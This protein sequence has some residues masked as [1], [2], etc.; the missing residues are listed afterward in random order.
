MK[1]NNYQ[2]TPET[3]AEVVTQLRT[4][5]RHSPDFRRV[6]TAMRRVY[7][8]YID[9]KTETV[10]IL[11]CGAFAKTDYLLKEY[12]AEPQMARKVNAARTRMRKCGFL[13][14]N[15]LREHAEDDVETLCSFVTLCSDEG[16]RRGRRHAQTVQSAVGKG[17]YDVLRMIVTHWDDDCVYGDID[18]DEWTGEATACYA[19]GNTHFEGDWTYLRK[20]FYAGAQLNLVRPEMRE[21]VLFPELIIFAPDYLVDISSVARC[22]TNY[23][24]SPVVTLIAKLQP[25]Q[26][27]EAIVLG[28]FAGQLLDEAVRNTDDNENSDGRRDY[29]DSVMEFFRNNAVSLLTAG[30]GPTFHDEARRQQK[31][32]EKAVK[33]DLKQAVACFEPKEGMV[34]PSFFSE[35]LGLQGRMDY[36]QLDFRVLMEQKSGKGGF[37][38]NGFVSPLHKEEHYVQLLLYMLLIRYNYRAVYEA[39]NRELH[40]FLLY[41]KYENPLLGLGFAPEL[42]FRAIKVRNRI[43]ASEL[44]Y[45]RE[46]AFRNVLDGLTPDRLNEKGD[47]GPLWQRYQRGQMMELLAPIHCATE[48]ERAYYYRFLTFIANEHVRS[49]LGNGTKECSGFAAT[50]QEPLEEKRMAGN[51]YDGLSLASPDADTQGAVETVKLH[52]NEDVDNDMAN[53]RTGDVVILYPYRKGTEPDARRMMVFRSRIE[54]IGADCITLS[55]RAPQSDARVFLWYKDMMWAIEHDFIEASYG[56]LYRGMHAFLSAPKDRRDLLMM[57]REPRIDTSLTLKGDYGGFNE[58]SLRVKQARDL[59]LIIGPPGTGKTSFGMLNTV[60]EELLEEGSSVLLLSYTN[61][62]VDEICSKLVED[63]IDFIRVGSALSSAPEYHD[64]LLSER[65]KAYKSVKGLKDML[66]NARVYVGT[67]TA[68]SSNVALLQI[69][70]FTLAVIDEASQILEPHLI[71]LLSARDGELSAIKKMV[72]IGD[73]KQLPAVVQQ[74]QDVSVVKE[75]MLHDI[76]LMDCRLSLFERLLRKYR[77][78]PAVTYMLSRQ[79]RM[80]HDIAMFPN[81]A[82]YN[83]KLSEVPLKHQLAGLPDAGNESDGM[84]TVLRSS[85]IAF[86]AAQEPHD[87][88]SDKVN[89]VE[90]DMIASAVRKIYEIEQEGFK[91]EETVGIIVPYRNQ[92]AA[93]R[94]IIDTYGIECLHDIAIDTVERFQGSQ[95]KYIIYGFTISKPYQLKFLTDNVFID[96]DGTVVDRKLNVAMTRA[97]EHLVMYGNPKLLQRNDTFARLMDFVKENGTFIGL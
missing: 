80:H 28:N 18:G 86:V 21:G 17:R 54:S 73:H 2:Y 74:P 48:L 92:I 35:M 8:R 96:T 27:T 43:A 61:R 59:F 78:N 30:I 85:R 70:Q 72:F 46:N 58:L 37:P 47:N 32:I 4:S 16:A 34:E 6:Y 67:T 66:E 33:A 82:F 39:N 77:D 64:Y 62:A 11:L 65:A 26:N 50:W 31:N 40:S 12:G 25:Q 60:K 45:T 23:A 97:E 95:R 93:I 49:K 15:D 9:Q 10:G 79:G 81:A 71:G 14:V 57:Q 29:N 75:E 53:F 5:L 1:S 38:F 88:A 84:E 56:S 13:P 63:G 42:V 41:S 20:L 94:N 22:F 91:T 89:M 51:I 24:E 19:H 83:G 87:S 3:A 69:K 52:F 76:G 90:A 68:L 55:L 7:R 44:Y 36:L